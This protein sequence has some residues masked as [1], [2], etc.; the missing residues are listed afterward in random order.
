MVDGRSNTDV[1]YV[2]TPWLSCRHMGRR[3]SDG[4]VVQLVVSS[5]WPCR[6]VGRVVQLAFSS[7]RSLNPSGAAH[8]G[9]IAP[10]TLSLPTLDLAVPHPNEHFIGGAWQPSSTDAHVTVINPSD[11]TVLT[12]LPDVVPADVDKA[13][14]AARRAF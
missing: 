1:D 5:N 11:E 7:T 2:V 9:G 14:A 6:P 10:M 3:R 8:H 12:E 4:L 13:I